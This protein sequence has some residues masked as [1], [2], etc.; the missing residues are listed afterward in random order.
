MLAEG[1]CLSLAFAVSVSYHERF[2]DRY[3]PFDLRIKRQGLTDVHF[4][5]RN[6]MHVR[7]IIV[8]KSSNGSNGRSGTSLLIIIIII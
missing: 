1:R 5:L 3:P 4:S 8:I 7:S 2:I 6:S